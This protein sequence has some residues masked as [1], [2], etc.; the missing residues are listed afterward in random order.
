[1]NLRHFKEKSCVVVGT[2][3][4]GIIE[5]GWLCANNIIAGDTSEWEV[6][7]SSDGDGLP[8]F[9]HPDFRWQCLRDRLTVTALGEKNPGEAVAGVFQ[10]LKHTPL[11]GV[12]NNFTF[13]PS[14]D[15]KISLGESVKSLS[16]STLSKLGIAVNNYST[17][18]QFSLNNAVL[19]LALRHTDSNSVSAIGFNFHRPAPKST[20]VVEAANLWAD[21]LRAASNFL[22]RLIGQQS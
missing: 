12:G 17:N 4:P 10:I 22:D 9:L 15:E 20:L 11:R 14:D 21:D 1:M 18:L 5:P 3:N 7:L 19:N 6:E 16:V 13:E 8:T 2:L